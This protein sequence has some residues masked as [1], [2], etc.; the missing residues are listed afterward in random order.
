M[1][2]WDACMDAGTHTDRIKANYALGVTKQVGSTPTFFVNGQM[3]RGA[4]NYDD[5]KA[6][7]DAANAANL[8]IPAVVPVPAAK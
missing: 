4:A 1:K 8:P 7:V 3:L 6:A 2:K 5:I